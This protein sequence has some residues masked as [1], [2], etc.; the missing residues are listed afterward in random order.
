MMLADPLSVEVVVEPTD[1]SVTVTYGTI[2][3]VA[4]VKC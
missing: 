2:V 1:R 4:G 3:L